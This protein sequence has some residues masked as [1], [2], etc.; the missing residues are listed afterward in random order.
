MGMN[1]KE[2]SQIRM[3]AHGVI[4]RFNEGHDW[5]AAVEVRRKGEGAGI[6][7][8]ARPGGEKSGDVML[9]LGNLADAVR[10]ELRL[11]RNRLGAAIYGTSESTFD[12]DGAQEFLF[13]VWHLDGALIADDE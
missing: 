13:D 1:D 4:A 12:M 11:E 2:L 10:M 5:A 6:T 8:K 3:M 9:E 7:V